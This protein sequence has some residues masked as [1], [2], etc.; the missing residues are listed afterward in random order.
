[1]I[2]QLARTAVGQVARFAQRTQRQSEYNGSYQRQKL[3]LIPLEAA[4][5]RS[6][7]T[8][9]V[10]SLILQYQRLQDD[11]HSILEG[12]PKENISTVERLRRWLLT[13]RSFQTALPMPLAKG[14]N[15]ALAWT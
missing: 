6:Y 8:E 9:D 4:M 10:K 3:V 14:V 2:R 1:M 7:S 11:L 5:A 12:T 13:A 15:S